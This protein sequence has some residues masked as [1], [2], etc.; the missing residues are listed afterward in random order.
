MPKNQQAAP[1]ES[2]TQIVEVAAATTEIAEYN[3]LVQAM[4]D[5]EVRYKDVVFDCSTPKGFEEAKTARAEIREVRYTLKK[6]E[7]VVLITYRDTVKAAQARVNEVK[8]FG[9]DL[10][11]RVLVLEEPIDEKIKAKEK[12][13]KEEKERK[14][15]IER[16]RIETIQNK[17]THFRGVASA[18]AARSSEDISAI[19]EHMKASAIDPD[20]YAEF[21]GEATIA[22]A[23][24]IDSLQA[25]HRLAI[26]REAADA[27]AKKDAEELEELR[28]RQKRL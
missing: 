9:D 4:Q 17:L 24:A 28:Q 22:R 13:D 6:T 5:L 15:E 7:G 16:V 14:E 19:L 2:Q 27:K 23:T 1:I 25:L 18:F 10:K 12:A 8:R 21:E 3:P 11:T 26:T 20:E